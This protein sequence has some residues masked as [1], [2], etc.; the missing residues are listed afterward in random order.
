MPD[1][2][3]GAAGKPPVDDHP[4][5][6]RRPERADW[7]LCLVCNL[8]I[9]AHTSRATEPVEALMRSEHA[10]PAMTVD[11]YGTAYSFG[12]GPTLPGTVEMKRPHAEQVFG[13]EVA[14]LI[15][16][17]GPLTRLRRRLGG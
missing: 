5:V 11:R 9:A 15:K 12:D 7:D 2:P 17:P 14:D 10:R 6:P 4:Y 1:Q 8:S 3:E 16:P 13:R